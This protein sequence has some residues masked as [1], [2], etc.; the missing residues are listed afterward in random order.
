MKG[1]KVIEFGDISD[2][3]DQYH[4][5]GANPGLYLGFNSMEPFYSMREDSCTDWTG[6]PQ[7][8]KTEL[9]LECLYNV[10]DFYGK[11][12]LLCVPDIG[13]AIEVM[14][15]LI[16]KHTGM[17]FDKRYN[18]FIDIKTA[19]KAS[20]WLLDK[21]HIL[22]KIDASPNC[23]PVEF[24][25]FAV[26]YKKQHGIFSAVI[27]SWKDLRHDYS[28][29]GGTYAQYLSNVLPIRNYLSEKH[30]IHFHTVIHPKT[31][32]RDSKGM[33]VHPQV[34]DMEGGAQWNNSG[35]TIISVHRE[36]FDTKIANVQMLKVKPKAIGKR[37]FFAI[38][39]DVAKSRYFD[40]DINNGGYN[41]YAQQKQEKLTPNINFY[42]TEKELPE[43]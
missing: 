35:K 25:E 28:K 41:I 9:M 15:I 20:A 17:T 29:Y 1:Y 30:K 39:F 5:N 43:Y 23:S 31:P 37:G 36:T 3:L 26:E 4:K 22:Q 6:L 32:R 21:F 40:L 14:A 27:D 34:D 8:G 24:W 7:S 18:N 42:E 12:H 13:D 10:S 11:K 33:L 19:Y 38:N 16:H 2:G